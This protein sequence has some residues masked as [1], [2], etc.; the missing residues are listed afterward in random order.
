MAIKAQLSINILNSTQVKEKTQVRNE[1]GNMIGKQN[2]SVNSVNHLADEMNSKENKLREHDQTVTNKDVIG[3]KN[4]QGNNNQTVTNKDEIG[5]KN[6]QGN[7]KIKQPVEDIKEDRE[8][9]QT[10]DEKKK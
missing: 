5:S 7:T 4:E 2:N 8:K 10:D 9:E 6:V 3:S 1:F